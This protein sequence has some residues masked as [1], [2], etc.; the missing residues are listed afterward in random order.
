MTTRRNLF[1]IA[2]GIAATGGTA[3]LIGSRDRAP[4]PVAVL[5]PAAVPDVLVADRRQGMVVV[6]GPRPL[7]FGTQAVAS[8]DGRLVYAV[9]E[10]S[11]LVRLDPA[12][13]VSTRSA[14][15]GG[16][17]T[18]RVISGDGRACALSRT[19]ASALPAA[20]TRTSL[21][22]TTDGRQRQYDL[23]GVVE[24]DAFTRDDGGLFVL[25]WLPAAAP[26]HYRVRLLDLASGVVQP[27]LT[28]A[29]APVPPG[30]EEE[31]RGDGRQAVPS[32]DGQI[33]Y[34]LYTHQP[35]H[36]HTR[37]LVAGRP[38]GVHAFVHVL[39]LT[40]RWAYC[41]DLPH[42]FGEGPVE[43]HAVAVTADGRDLAVLD[44][45]S[46]TLAY[47]DTTALT[48]TRLDRL[49]A[50]D[51]AASLAFTPDGRR[52]LAGAGTAVTVLDR[53]AGRVVARWPVPGPVRGL[54]LSRD[55]TRVYAGGTDEVVWLDAESGALRGRATIDGLTAL[56][57]VR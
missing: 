16:G 25:D 54:G 50:A 32:P 39:H 23:A 40:E 57:H 14:V 49:P 53:G 3:A 51:G 37:D 6:G 12:S 36:R 48:I 41:L 27:L 9:T 52:A 19:P 47:A 26:D 44:A 56:R 43:G 28:R 55:A 38:G 45:K 11:I 46:G 17:W 8:P 33:L 24:P 21:L 13:G 35:G 2:G 34:T 10:G 30:A 22:V 4:T 15:L 1:I 7:D 42:P 20:R 31:M 5:G 29:K 18:P